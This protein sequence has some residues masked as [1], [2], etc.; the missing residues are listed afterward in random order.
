MIYTDPSSTGGRAVRSPIDAL[1][2]KRKQA[3][4]MQ[5][6]SQPNDRLVCERGEANVLALRGLPAPDVATEARDLQLAWMQISFF[7]S[8]IRR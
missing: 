6:P 3:H 8:L 1:Q 7:R 4:E 2:A 5:R